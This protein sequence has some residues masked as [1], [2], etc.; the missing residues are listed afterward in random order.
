MILS[1]LKSYIKNKISYL[2][3]FFVYLR[4]KIFIGLSI[5]IV[6]GLLDG[7]GLTMFLPLFQMISG[8]FDT[9]DNSSRGLQLL[10]EL[11]GNIDPSQRL[12]IVLGF[13]V[14]FFT[15][16]GI[17]K[18]FNLIYRVTQ[19][20]ELLRKI[21]LKL[22]SKLEVVNYRFFLKSDAGRIQ[23]TLTAE[24]D[25]IQQ[26]FNSYFQAFEQMILVLVYML[27]AFYI[28]PNF[29]ILVI[30][31]GG[32]TNFIYQI[33]Y[34]KT[35]GASVRLTDRSNSF[36]G[37]VSQMIIN[38]KYLR[39]TGSYPKYKERLTDVIHDLEKN[40]KKIGSLGALL[41]GSRE[42]L[43]M[44]VVSSVILVQ[45]EVLNGNM[46]SILISLMFFYR[47]LT[48]VTQMQ[49]SWNRFLGVSGSL[50]NLR[51]F[52]HDLSI[53]S[54]TNNGTTFKELAK[55]IDLRGVSVAYD[56]KIVLNDINIS[57]EKHKSY[58]IVGES[59]SGK[60]TLLNIISGLISPTKGEIYIDDQRFNNVRRQDYQSKI[61]YITQ[62]PVIFEGSIFDNITLW[63]DPN[64]SNIEKCKIA[65]QKALI[66]DFVNDSKDGIYSQ[67]GANGINLSGGQKQRISIAREL[68][69]DVEL[70]LMD[71]ATSALDSETESA[72]KSNIDNLI[73]DYTIIIIAHRLATIKNID[74][75][76]LLD[77]T[78]V[79]MVGTFQDLMGN[80][81][82]FRS[83]AELQKIA[84]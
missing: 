3:W 34:K 22:L 49:N 30:I 82:K 59:G 74:T 47:A 38:F 48:A 39:S 5:A 35:K 28:D 43:L 51:D 15:L 45:V 77:A 84:D 2:L 36:Q 25:R 26:A 57:F 73:G 83:M 14:L 58:A 44:L 64:N 63:S 60:T 18:Y 79:A 10:F 13:I 6:V 52:E 75:L 40:R 76:I 66:F 46:S 16:K 19:Q 33:V 24:V 71:E 70:L 41:E 56:D 12:F 67:L 50:F 27:F 53:N 55:R 42:P 17:A 65:L 4:Q 78:K 72:I 21:R 32:S 1:T 31:G 29:A 20:Q 69:R 80:S 62:E 23:N 8:D 81:A 9:D 61:G 37:K 68:Y 7:I 54:D 11:I